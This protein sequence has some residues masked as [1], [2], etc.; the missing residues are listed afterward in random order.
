[1]EPPPRRSCPQGDSELMQGEC[2]QVG[3]SKRQ[4]RLWEGG[5]CQERGV[6]CALGCCLDRGQSQERQ[7]QGLLTLTH[8]ALGV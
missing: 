5:C 6:L 7:L 1:M 4:S 8:T 2:S 3:V